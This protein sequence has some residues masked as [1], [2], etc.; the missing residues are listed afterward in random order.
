MS[1]NAC[2]S[3]HRDRLYEYCIICILNSDR[4]HIIHKL[5]IIKSLFINEEQPFVAF[6]VNHYLIYFGDMYAYLKIYNERQKL[7]KN[8]VSKKKKQQQQQQK[9]THYEVWPA[10]CMVAYL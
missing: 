4:F 10:S 8:Q 2:C 6:C 1:S 7:F 5:K 3:D 9:L